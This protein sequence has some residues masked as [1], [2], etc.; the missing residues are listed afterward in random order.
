MTITTPR[1]SSPVDT[2]TSAETI[3]STGAFTVG[4]RAL[5]DAFKTLSWATAGRRA[6]PVFSSRVRAT[7]LADEV[8][9]CAFDGDNAV[10]VTVPATATTPGRMLLEHTSALKVLAAAVKGARKP[11]LDALE[12]R[13]TTDD[14]QPVIHVLGYGV[15]LDANVTV[16]RFPD[17]PPTTPASHVL[18]RADFAA[19][20]DR[21][22]PAVDRGDTLPILTGVHTV[23]TP[24]DV[25][26]TA[27]DRYRLATGTVAAT[28]TTCETVLIPGLA[29]AKVMP[30]LSGDEIRIGVDTIDDSTWVTI[31]SDT[32]TARIRG[33]D[34]QYPTV[35]SVLDQTATRTVIIDRA[36]LHQAATRA[37]ALTSA[38]AVR[39]SPVRI[40]VAGNSLTIDPASDYPDKVTSPSVP[41]TTIGDDADWVSGVNPP[42]LLDAIASLTTDQVEIHLSEPR[43]PL[44]LTDHSDEKPTYRH[45]LMPVRV[46]Q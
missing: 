37:A 14:A 25:T 18:T 32:T 23:L 43:K 36:Q 38:T 46:A 21:V 29:L 24:S 20:L 22:I 30:H 41:T 2:S 40:V 9:L 39:N 10:T 33:L 3:L 15:P 12:V 5:V 11:E 19:L 26:C 13:I 45:L 1:P 16:D 7:V 44:V 42:F 35:A 31:A 6:M 27:T 34:G 17:L 8:E 4:Y 28:G